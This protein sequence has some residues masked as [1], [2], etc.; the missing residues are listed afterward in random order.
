MSVYVKILKEN[1][2]ILEKFEVSQLWLFGSV[3]KEDSEP[4]DIDILVKFAHDPKLLQFMNLKFELQ[5]LLG[6]SI[7]LHS[8]GSCPARFYDRIKGDLLRVA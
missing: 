6:T 3:V 2:W 4:N 5:D 7:D 8:L 1:L